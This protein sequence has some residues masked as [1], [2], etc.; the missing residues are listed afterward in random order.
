MVSLQGRGTKALYAE[1]LADIDGNLEVTGNSLRRWHPLEALGQVQ[2]R[3]CARSGE[4]VP[5]ALIRRIGGH[6]ECPRR[7]CCHWDGRISDHRIAR[8]I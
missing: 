8:L 3:P 1:G 2:D 4:Q 5:V 6:E 7:H